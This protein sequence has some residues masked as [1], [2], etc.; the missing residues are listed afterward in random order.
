MKV[1][2]RIVILLLS[3]VLA[4]SACGTKQEVTTGQDSKAK[5]DE[6]KTA[7]KGTTQTTTQNKPKEEG[8]N[9]NQST[10]KPQSDTNTTTNPPAQQPKSNSSDYSTYNGTWTDSDDY[11]GNGYYLTLQFTDKNKAN[12]GLAAA[13]YGTKA[14]KCGNTKPD[15]IEDAVVTFDQTGVGTY[16]FVD[17]R[18]GETQ[19][20][21]TIKLANNKVTLT[22]KHLNHP[23]SSDTLFGDNRTTELP[24]HNKK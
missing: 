22:T 12:V 4:L 8:T 10:Q 7:E 23:Q 13:M 11:C 24:Y 20:Q 1:R 15:N 17:G 5:T 9:T 3:C 14:Q 18:D 21:A 19:I 16:T 6:T 2:G